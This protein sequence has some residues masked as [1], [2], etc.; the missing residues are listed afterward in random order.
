MNVLHLSFFYPD[1]VEPVTT[2]AIKRLIDCAD[3]FADNRR[4]SL[5]MFLPRDGI[6]VR[7]GAG[8]TIVC[9]RLRAFPYGMCAF[10]AR[11][12]GHLDTV[13]AKGAAFDLTHPHLLTMEGELAL[14]IKQ[15]YGVP[16]VASVRATDFVLFRFKPYMKRRYL[17][18]VDAAERLV[19]IA[20]WMATGLARVFGREWTE[21][22]ARKITFLYNIVDGPNRWQPA[23]NGRYALPIVAH[24]SQLRRKRIKATLRAI[25]LLR[26]R[27]HRIELDIFGDGDGMDRIARWVG[28]YGLRSQVK[29]IGVLPNDK[30]IRALSEYKALFL[31]SMP[32]TFGLVYIEA[33]KAGIPIVYSART[34]IDGVF[35]D[36][37]IGVAAAD[38]SP[39]GLADAFVAMECRHREYKRAVRELQASDAL[40]R[41][42]SRFVEGRL[43]ELYSEAVSVASGTTA[44]LPGR[45]PV[46]EEVT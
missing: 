46:G 30:M 36:A 7:A 26:D 25:A 5:H 17:E 34:G 35:P 33:L 18:I 19:L 31:C 1:E 41:F 27:G 3:A 40:A 37:S 32:E 12:A 38:R 8:H 28:R 29:F 10:L 42:T 14:R 43:H 4:I 24:R 23:H 9:E 6:R 2:H 39:N 16:F 45:H 11:C 20:P 21:A 13:L 44:H 15:R 22:R